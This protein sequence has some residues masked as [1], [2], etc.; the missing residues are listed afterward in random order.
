MHQTGLLDVTPIRKTEG[1]PNETFFVLPARFVAGLEHDELFAAL[2]VTDI[3]FSQKRGFM[4]ER[5][6]RDVIP[7]FC[8]I[9]AMERGCVALAVPGSRR[10]T[11]GRR[12]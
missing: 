5:E 2:R 9:A 10:C 12:C 1:I 6:T 7:P 4:T 11:P 3:G 8:C